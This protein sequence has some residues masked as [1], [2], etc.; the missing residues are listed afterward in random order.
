MSTRKISRHSSV[1]VLCAILYKKYKTFFPYWYTVISTLVKIGKTRN[2]VKTLRPAGVAQFLV[3]PIS[4]RVDITV[5]Q[6]GK[7]FIFLKCQYNWCPIFLFINFTFMKRYLKSLKSFGGSLKGRRHPYST[8]ISSV[9]S[10]VHSWWR[11]SRRWVVNTTRS[12][13]AFIQR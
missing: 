6:H 2:C 9:V 5:Y 1:K 11:L 13:F 10:S 8:C 7:C 3:F 12:G 4:T